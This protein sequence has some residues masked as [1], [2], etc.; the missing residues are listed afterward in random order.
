MFFVFSQHNI[1]LLIYQL[2]RILRDSVY[3]GLHEY[4]RSHLN[5][6]YNTE[7]ANLEAFCVQGTGKKMI[8]NFPSDYSAMIH[9]YLFNDI[10]LLLFIYVLLGSEIFLANRP[11]G[12]SRKTIICD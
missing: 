1:Y 5:A 12:Q 11:F 6:I 9:F 2:Y 10:L 4:R 3:R 7:A 8:K